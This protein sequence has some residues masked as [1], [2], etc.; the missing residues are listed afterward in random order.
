M[1]SIS[2]FRQ[3]P[4]TAYLLVNLST[5]LWSSNVA[6]GRLLHSQVGPVT[7]SAARFTLGALLFALLLRRT[8]SLNPG[9]SPLTR[10]DLLL[11]AGMGLSGVFTFPI[12][13]YLS[14]RYTTATNVALIN[15]TGPL[16]TLLLAALFL[17]ERVSL[18]LGLGGL[19]SLAGVG[20]LIS[21]NGSPGYIPGLGFNRGEGLALLAVGLWGVYS[22]LGRL[23][24][25]SHSSLRVT[26]VSTW[27]ALPLLLLA[28]ALEWR[29][30]PPQLTPQVILSAV[31]IGVFPTVI[32]FLSWNEG[33]RRVG[34]NQAMA[35]YNTL[36]LFGAMLGYFFL[37][38]TLTANTMFG[39]L[40]VVGGGLLAAL[41][42]SPSRQRLA[43]KHN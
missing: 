23:A 18:V 3:D 39:G 20:L 13:L 19:V 33:I 29:V 9:R 11:M 12:L 36:P 35:F 26:A 34:P 40:M 1:P 14:L 22:I 32:A 17:S 4:R 27:M 38:E 6:L 24:T 41:Y 16:L 10:R 2:Q 25:R 42:G 15:G 31:Y 7:L 43:R 8:S 21:G 28:S 37:C 5:L 30:N